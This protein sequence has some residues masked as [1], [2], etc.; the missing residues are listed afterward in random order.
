MYRIA[1]PKDTLIGAK[2]LFGT[3]AI[4]ACGGLQS[5][6]CDRMGVSGVPGPGSVS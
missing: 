5:V 6:A 1:L 3:G 4:Y 2:P